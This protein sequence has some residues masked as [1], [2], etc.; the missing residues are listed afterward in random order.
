VDVS[1]VWCEG[2]NALGNGKF[3]SHRLFQNQPE[4]WE[5]RFAS[6]CVDLVAMNSCDRCLRE[7]ILEWMKLQY[8]CIRH[9]P[10]NRRHRNRIPLECGAAHLPHVVVRR[11]DLPVRPVR[12]GPTA[13][14]SC[15][16]SVI[17]RHGVSVVEE[18]RDLH[19]VTVA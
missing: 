17:E 12:E 5:G 3:S 9:E 13:V 4:Y 15:G 7:H 18:G 14:D 19:R 16:P 6:L 1:R 11:M 10:R 2:S 8:A